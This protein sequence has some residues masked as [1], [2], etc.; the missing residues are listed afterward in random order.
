MPETLPAVKT[1]LLRSAFEKFKKVVALDPTNADA[2][3][4]LAQCMHSIVESQEIWVDDKSLLAESL[5]IL[6]QCQQALINATN[7]PEEDRPAIELWDILLLRVDI[8]TS[9]ITLLSSMDLAHHHYSQAKSLLE[10]C[11]PKDQ[12][13][14]IQLHLKRAQLDS[15]CGQVYCAFSQTLDVS[16]FDSSIALLDGILSLNP[17]HLEALADKGEVLSD[18]ADLLIQC[19]GD[20]EKAK[21]VYA[22]AVE[23][24]TSALTLSPNTVSLK[25]HLGSLHLSRIRAYNAF[26]DGKTRKVLAKNARI[27]YQSCLSEIPVGHSERRYVL[28]HLL[29]ACSYMDS[30][31]A[32]CDKCYEQLQKEFGLIDFQK[33]EDEDQIGGLAFGSDEWKPAA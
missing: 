5:Q 24:I 16:F 17:L 7:L 20:L 32:D 3:Y 6:D 10:S 27:Y 9:F 23:A 18:Y 1:E 15:C 22:S 26:E 13:S 4:N 11:V 31:S 12:A 25:L 33:W 29:K 2:L 28:Y 14:T 8:H 30:A 21:K 19:A